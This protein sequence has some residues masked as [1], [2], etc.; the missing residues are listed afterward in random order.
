M[1]SNSAATP[2]ACPSARPSSRRPA[3]P[4]A[5]RSPPR[6]PGRPR[7]RHPR[8]GVGADVDVADEQGRGGRRTAHDAASPIPH[9]RTAFAEL[10]GEA[11]EDSAAAPGTFRPGCPPR[12]P[13]DF[14]RSPAARGTV[15]DRGACGMSAS[16]RNGCTDSHMLH[17]P[18]RGGRGTRGVRSERA[19]DGM[20]ERLNGS[21][22]GPRLIATAPAPSRATR[23]MTAFP[24]GRAEAKLIRPG[25][26]NVASSM[27]SARGAAASG[28]HP[29][30]PTEPLLA[31]DGA[32]PG[33][34]R[35]P[36]V[37]VRGRGGHPRAGRRRMTR[38]RAVSLG[39]G[40]NRTTADQR[41]V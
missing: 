32:A 24:G 10:R 12:C 18:A 41:P 33:G 17:R 15:P 9:W 2:R 20:T 27:T 5:A 8:I 1:R 16:P 22:P 37:G 40:V 36:S 34:R 29:T 31:R 7:A 38:P 4:G 28:W 39:A 3:R 19:T 30:A 13:A 23:P 25:S 11:L 14:G 26:R 6:L 35:R 21:A